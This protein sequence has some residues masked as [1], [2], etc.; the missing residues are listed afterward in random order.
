MIELLEQMYMYVGYLTLIS[1]LV[2]VVY[3]FMLFVIIL[4]MYIYTLG[5]YRSEILVLETMVFLD[6]CHGWMSVTC[7]VCDICMLI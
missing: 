5:V 6:V 3:T 4:C 7:D 2:Y 1:T